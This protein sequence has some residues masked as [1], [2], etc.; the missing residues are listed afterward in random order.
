[1]KRA[2]VYFANTEGALVGENGGF[3]DSLPRAKFFDTP[4]HTLIELA[5]ALNLY[6]VKVRPI[7]TTGTLTLY[8]D[9]D[10]LLTIDFAND[11]PHFLLYPREAP[12]S[13]PGLQ[14]HIAGLTLAL[15]L[16]N[17]RWT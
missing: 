8:D 11:P 9:I 13:E 6:P 10:D 4:D 1:M 17:V 16:A 2:F 5:T 7:G 14:R 15:K 3:T 12:F